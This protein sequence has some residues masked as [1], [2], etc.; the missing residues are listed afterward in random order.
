MANIICPY[1]QKIY[2]Q[3]SG[4]KDTH[5]T[6]NNEECQTRFKQDFWIDEDDDE[7]FWSWE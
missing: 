4:L 7:G 1:C 2:W 5:R 6:C 3:Y